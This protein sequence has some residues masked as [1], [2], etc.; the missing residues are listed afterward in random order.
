VR[1]KALIVVLLALSVSVGCRI[2]RQSEIYTFRRTEPGGA[3]IVARVVIV[4]NDAKLGFA[5]NSVGVTVKGELD[6]DRVKAI[7]EAITE[8]IT[9]S[10][11]KND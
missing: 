8:A 5:T 7:T 1:K 11:K 10:M 6:K 9:K 2:H 3:R 4:V